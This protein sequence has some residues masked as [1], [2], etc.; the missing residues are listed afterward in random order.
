MK[1]FY[2]EE[3]FTDVLILQ[4]STSATESFQI[5][6]FGSK[7]E[8]QD[9]IKFITEFFSVEC[10][11]DPIHEGILSILTKDMHILPIHT[12]RLTNIYVSTPAFISFFA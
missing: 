2:R 10:K 7:M 9:T 6:L 4:C 12:K 1:K 11:T 5:H 8:E 3:K